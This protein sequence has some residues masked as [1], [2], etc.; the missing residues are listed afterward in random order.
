MSDLVTHL[1][2]T[3]RLSGIRHLCLMKIKSLLE[4]YLENDA[5]VGCHSIVIL[6]YAYEFIGI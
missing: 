4:D 2:V 6:S 5:C 3:A 1:L